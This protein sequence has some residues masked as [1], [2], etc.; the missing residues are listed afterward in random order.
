MPERS[1]HLHEEHDQ[2]HF[3][4]VARPENSFDIAEVVRSL[5]NGGKRP[6]NIMWILEWMDVS[7]AQELALFHRDLGNS[8]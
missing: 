6:F 4:Q 5:K 2:N 7:F 3:A 1:K 8:R